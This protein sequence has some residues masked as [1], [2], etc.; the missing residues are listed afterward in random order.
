[1][2][3]AMHVLGQGIYGK[4]LYLPLNLAVHLKCSKTISEIL[5]VVSTTTTLDS[6]SHFLCTSD[7]F[8]MLCKEDEF[9]VDIAD[10]CEIADQMNIFIEMTKTFILEQL[11]STRHSINYELGITNTFCSTL[12]F[13]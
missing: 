1:M 3:Q 5:Y 2:G 13:I 11:A 6:G 10:Y 12:T 4:S 8:E 7:D 9:Y